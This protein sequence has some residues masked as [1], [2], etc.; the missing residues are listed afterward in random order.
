MKQR[1]DKTTVRLSQIGT[2]SISKEELR[3]Y[4]ES[5]LAFHGLDL[6]RISS[7][8]VAQIYRLEQNRV[9]NIFQIMDE[10]K[11]LEAL[12][13]SSL[14]EK[15][16]P[17]KGPILK[18]LHKKHFTDAHFI[19]KNIG[20]H[21]GYGKDKMP[22]LDRIIR[23]AFKQNT[24][25]CVDDGFINYI[26]HHT[27]VGAYEERAR[28]CLTGEWI[29]FKKHKGKNYYLTLAAH[30]EGDENIMHRV[31]MACQFDF[32]FLHKRE[33]GVRG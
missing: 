20:N 10:V 2:V 18:G 33:S 24:S 32:P 23:E 11:H 27:T 12:K 14:T 29:V 22:R 30:D 3:K 15:E 9:L 5:N 1:G 4:A 26:A 16:G 21:L 28:N 13:R 17:F 6:D 19:L 31:E 7:I 8:F 25:G